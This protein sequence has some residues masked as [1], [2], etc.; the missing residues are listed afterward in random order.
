MADESQKTDTDEMGNFD[1]V[2]NEAVEPDPVPDEESGVQETT[3][4]SATANEGEESSDDTR[5]DAG[6]QRKPKGRRLQKRIDRLTK[7]ATEAERRAA[8][9]EAK[10]NE[11]NKGQAQTATEPSGDAETSESGTEPDPS[12][13]D[14]YDDYL[15]DLSKYKAGDK[16]EPAEESQSQDEPAQVDDAEYR[17]AL[18][19]VQEAF[20][21]SREQFEDFDAV[22]TQDDLTITPD[23][24]KAMSEADDPGAIAYHLGKNK[25]EAS[26]I[27]EL[28]AAGQAR[29]IGKLEV[30]LAN[31]PKQPTKKTTQTPDPIEPVRGSDSTTKDAANMTFDEYESTMNER[32]QRSGRGFW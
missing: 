4:E 29:E 31:K 14:N 30:S 16:Q 7:R 10:V 8:E 9:L 1:V 20:T 27:A 15:T 26:R 11:G 22:I 6:E 5:R 17:E 18:A 24:V 21:E 32:E 2:T 3:G 19:D 28:S 12:D 25:A 23:M 13:Y